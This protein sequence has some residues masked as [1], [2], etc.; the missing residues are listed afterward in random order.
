MAKLI[1]NQSGHKDV[2]NSLS[3]ATTDQCNRSDHKA[4]KCLC[5]IGA[6]EFNPKRNPLVVLMRK[7]LKWGTSQ[8]TVLPILLPSEEGGRM[9]KQKHT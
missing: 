9:Q 7:Q 8:Q 4:G 6:Q 2:I 1:K 5:T 3:F